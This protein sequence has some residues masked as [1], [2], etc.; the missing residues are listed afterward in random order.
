MGQDGP[1][2]GLLGLLGCPEPGQPVAVLLL[3]FPQPEEIFLHGQAQVR[4]FGLERDVLGAADIKGQAF[5]FVARLIQ[6]ARAVLFGLFGSGAQVFFLGH[7]GSLSR[8]V[9]L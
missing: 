7:V 8:Y 6:Q 9:S 5:G 3:A 2:L 1:P 4:R